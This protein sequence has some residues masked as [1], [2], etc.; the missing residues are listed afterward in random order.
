V[1]GESTAFILPA[2]AFAIVLTLLL[3]VVLLVFVKRPSPSREASGAIT[4]TIAAVILLSGVWCNWISPTYDTRK[5]EEIAVRSLLIEPLGTVTQ[6]FEAEKGQ[7]IEV[8]IDFTGPVRVIQVPGRFEEP[9]FPIFSVKI[10]DPSGRLIWAQINVT[11]G[12]F[13]QPTSVK[14][15]GTY[16]IEVSNHQKEV[17]SLTMR[18]QDRAKITVRPLEPLGQWLTLI[19]IP[20]FGL[21]VWFSRLKKPDQQPLQT[22]GDARLY[23]AG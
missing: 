13:M 18:V 1:N 10:Y 12:F 17:V 11:K 15:S 23:Q 22:L 5:Y 16:R 6:T 9:I 2:I 14:E 20:I 21:G 7:E 19:S 8:N 3:L 4:L